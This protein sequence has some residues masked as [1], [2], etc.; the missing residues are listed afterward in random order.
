[1]NA[2]FKDYKVK[3]Y[4]KGFITCLRTMMNRETGRYFERQVAIPIGSIRSVSEIRHNELGRGIRIDTGDIDVAC[5]IDVYGAQ[6]KH[7]SNAITFAQK[8]S[9]V[10]DDDE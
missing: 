8:G 7:V 5:N 10:I 3:A 9:P 6:M 1:M 4:A 2:Y